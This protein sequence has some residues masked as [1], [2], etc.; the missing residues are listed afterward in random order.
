MTYGAEKKGPVA[1]IATPGTLAWLADSHEAAIWFKEP[2]ALPP[3]PFVQVRVDNF[4]LLVGPKDRST[5]RCVVF[6]LDSDGS[7][8]GT[9]ARDNDYGPV[10]ARLVQFC[11]RARTVPVQLPF[12]WGVFRSGDRYAFAAAP[13]AKNP[14]GLRCIAQV[15]KYQRS[16]AVWQF[17]SRGRP[18]DVD[19]VEIDQQMIQNA[20]GVWTQTLEEGQAVLTEAKDSAATERR[21]VIIESPAR[22]QRPGPRT[23]DQWQEHLTKGQRQFLDND[24]ARN[25]NLRGPAGSGKTLALELKALREVYRVRNEGRSCRVLFTTHSWSSTG[26][27]EQDLKALDVRDGIT[28]I[29]VVP[30]SWLAEDLTPEGVWRPTGMSLLGDDSHTSKRAQLQIIGQL[31]E[32]FLEQDW[33]TYRGSASSG[34][35]SRLDAV[36]PLEREA[37]L[38]DL[39]TEF[40][41]VL[42]AENI[43][44]GRDANSRYMDLRRGLWMMPLEADTDREVVF[45]LYQR[46]LAELRTR[47]F[48]TTD[49]LMSEFLKF[50][51]GP[52]WDIEREVRGYDL[53]LVDEVH[54]FNVQEKMALQFLMSDPMAYIRVC[55]AMDL[56]QSPRVRSGI[57]SES[58]G[59]TE[60]IELRTVH[61]YSPEILALIRHIHDAYPALELGDDWALE[62]DAVE[63]SADHGPKPV[64][65]VVAGSSDGVMTSS[66]ARAHEL[67]RGVGQTALLVIDDRLYDDYARFAEGIQGVTVISARDDLLALQHARK[68]LVVGLAEYVAGLQFENVLIVGVPED[69]SLPDCPAYRQREALTLLYL[70]ASRAERQLEL[71]HDRDLIVP[72]VLAAAIRSKIVVELKR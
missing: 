48:V 54:L 44:R 29:E 63:S 7:L 35:R 33:F 50:L 65:H 34:F 43:F 23:Y 39:L 16:V 41:C 57:P 36:D 3:A 70:A 64:L 51:Q 42:A 18:V 21:R 68:A 52:V 1:V 4:V 66:F 14:R 2:T 55:A 25:L 13:Y 49:I 67:R 6:R 27:V 56:R 71:F 58:D 8:L 62:L 53:V 22:G 15:E 59:D 72:S 9:E 46:Y 28:S 11:E 47:S 26:Q 38:E 40:G 60:S 24:L 19:K 5:S 32:T 12:N 31:V 20:V 45:S 30:L 69:L 10:L 37:L 61:R 17:Y